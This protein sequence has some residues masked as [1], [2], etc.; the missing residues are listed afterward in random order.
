MIVCY[1]NAGAGAWCGLDFAHAFVVCVFVYT[2]RVL[3]HSTHAPVH[4]FQAMQLLQ[5]TDS[6]IEN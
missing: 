3:Q 5:H 6:H 2:W 1:R 4:L